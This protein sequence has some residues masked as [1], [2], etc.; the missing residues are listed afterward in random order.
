MVAQADTRGRRRYQHEVERL[1]DQIQRQVQELRRM[2][3]VG[4]PS[5]ALAERKQRLAQTR[6]QLAKLVST[7]AASE[8]R[9]LAHR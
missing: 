7:G 4:I 3:V 8:R 9:V 5:R 6:E 1:L 2:K